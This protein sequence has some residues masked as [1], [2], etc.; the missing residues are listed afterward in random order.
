MYTYQ[1][2]ERFCLKC[3]LVVS[4]FTAVFCDVEPPHNLNSPLEV[5]ALLDDLSEPHLS[6]MLG[7]RDPDLQHIPDVVGVLHTR[8]LWDTC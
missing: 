5:E 8:Q 4:L 2:S 3:G 7:G 1:G 6:H